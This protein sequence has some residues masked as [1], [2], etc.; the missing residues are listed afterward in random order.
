M[1][2][3]DVA[4]IGGGSAGLAALKEL[5]KLGLQAVV[6][7][8]G[9]PVGSKNMTGGILYSKTYPSAKVHNVEDVY[10]ESFLSEA[11]LERRI[12]KYY[13]NAVSGNKAYT[14]DLTEAHNYLTNYAYS[15]LMAKM[16]KWFAKQ[17]EEEAAR[18]GGGIVSGVHVSNIDQQNGKTI[19]EIDELDPIEV[20]ALIAADGVNSETAL[21]TGARQ[22]LEPESLYQGV[23]SVV[24][25]PED[26][27]DERY[28]L[29]DGEGIAHLFAGDISR[30]HNGGGFLYTNRDTLS[31]GVVYHLDSL[32]K[33]PIEPYA[34]L[35]S[36][37]RIPLVGNYIKDE[38][39][40]VKEIDRD[41]PKEDQLRKK[42]GTSK[43]LKSWEELR[44]T[45][46]SKTARNNAIK[47]GFYKDDEEIKNRLQD[48]RKQLE[49]K[50]GVSFIT[51]YVELE[52]AAKIVPDGKR[53][54]MEKPY[55]NNVLFIGDAAGRGLFVGTRIEGINIGI[56]DAVRA[57]RAIARAK[58]RN[59]FS[60]QYLGKYYGQLIEESPYT[61]DLRNVD[62]QYMRI[63]VNA[64]RDIPTESLNLFLRLGFA[65]L[66]K[67]S[68]QDLAKG[69]AK[70]LDQR[71]LLYLIESNEAY[72]KIPMEIAEKI[73][74]TVER[75][76]E[77]KPPS[78]EE[79]IAK[80]KISDDPEPHI[81]II[82]PDTKFIKSMVHLCPTQCYIME[83]ID[84]ESFKSQVVL[85]HEGC[86]ECG[87]CSKE[88]NW[89]HP[90]GEKGVI[91][92]YG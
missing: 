47:Q 6:L 48:T 67:A 84:R 85:Q 87:T 9:K 40:F 89:K 90:K 36:F 72:V 41:L 51:N 46:Y 23:K 88:T 10:G 79:R 44:Y 8:A 4:I 34:L 77:I 71:T 86:I 57:A 17:A 63:F 64:C 76:F 66:S 43:L 33:S 16:N 35:D 69:I 45:Y 2:K 62:F 60:E 61:N 32:I 59:E 37:L 13:L 31:V 1:E 78:I 91:Y 7:E 27:I 49:E 58:E 83:L 80:I 68:V 12:A 24:R 22:K 18:L 81:K 3:Y 55:K 92:E 15:V 75:D 82:D 74:R 21:I 30:G 70:M 25:L 39:P 65:L 19:V 52:Y 20:S 28:D 73:G 29:K 50:F 5:S 54:M 53:A 11:P 26:I 38:V 42:F 56:D 14:V